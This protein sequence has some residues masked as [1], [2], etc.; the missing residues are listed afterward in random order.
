MILLGSITPKNDVSSRHASEYLK[1]HTTFETTSDGFL[2]N[3]FEPAHG[4]F[5]SS[6]LELKEQTEEQGNI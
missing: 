5:V 2:K 4:D 6:W 3:T 1:Y